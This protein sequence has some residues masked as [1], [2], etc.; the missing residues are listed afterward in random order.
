M[1]S[2]VSVRGLSKLYRLGNGPR[3]QYRTLRENLS[4]SAGMAWARLRGLVRR[5]R[6]VSRRGETLWALDGVSFDVRPGETVG[7]IGCNGAGKSTLLKILSR[8]TE[9]TAGRAELRGT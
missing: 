6:A 7:I 1:K 8:I 9:P 3:G 4:H 2:A 5:D